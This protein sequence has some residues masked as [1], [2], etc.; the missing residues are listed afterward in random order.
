MRAVLSILLGGSGAGVVD[1]LVASGGGRARSSQEFSEGREG[2]PKVRWPADCCDECVQGGSSAGL[3]TLPQGLQS[4]Q[5]RRIKPRLAFLWALVRGGNASRE[6]P[7]TAIW[8][9]VVRTR[10]H[11][12]RNEEATSPHSKQS[13]NPGCDAATILALHCNTAGRPKARLSCIVSRKLSVLSNL[14]MPSWKGQV[15]LLAMP[16]WHGQESLDLLS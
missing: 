5:P 6:P 10:L 16:S 4:Q 7:V 14:A 12:L 13:P 3:C 1:W 8:R 2:E 15:G 11:A 9:S